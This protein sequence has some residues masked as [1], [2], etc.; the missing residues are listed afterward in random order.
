MKPIHLWLSTTAFLIFVGSTEAGL[1]DPA[2]SPGRS[3][4]PS[5][6]RSASLA[7][8][9]RGQSD[10]VPL[11]QGTGPQAGSGSLSGGPATSAQPGISGQ[12]PVGTLSTPSLPD[13][14]TW[15]AFS[16]PTGVDPFAGAQQSP[17]AP[18]APYTPYGNPYGGGP[19]GQ[20][21]PFSTFGANGPHPYRRGWQNN[22]EIGWMPGASVTGNASGLFEQFDVDFDL[23]HTG[24]FMPGWMLTWTNQFR[25]RLW[26]GP[27]PL[28][29]FPGLPSR[30]FRFGWDFELETPKSGPCSIS[31]G[32]TP[33]INSDLQTSLSSNAY[34]LDFRGMFIFQID[35]YWSMVLGAGY[36]DRVRDRVIPYAGLT[37]RDDYWE[38]Q[39]MFPKSTISLFLGNEQ[40]WSKWA[41]L[42]AEYHVE[43][44]EVSTAPGPPRDEVE[45]ED[46]RILLGFRMDGGLYSWFMEGGWVFDREVQFG[47]GSSFSPN[48]GFIGRMGWQY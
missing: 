36:W 14:S 41:Y 9:F 8:V 30:A 25:L 39:L 21:V 1:F 24:P 4:Q 48:T 45:L 35:Q 20:P 18:Y 34:Q 44:Y 2:G 11:P 7:T 22:L 26:D 33:S 17:Q 31:L 12:N 3:G 10:G 5:I 46:Y 16:P 32:F 42:T 29:G 38:W 15:N 43:A 27:T 19:Y 40:L 23:A 13:A 37:Y 28:P 6:Y 47:L